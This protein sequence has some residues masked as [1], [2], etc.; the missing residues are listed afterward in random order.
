MFQPARPLKRLGLSITHVGP[1]NPTQLRAEA[2]QR[3][4]KGIPK[5]YQRDTKGIPKGYQ[6]DTKGIPKGYQK[7]TKGIPKVYKMDTKGIP[8]GYIAALFVSAW[9]CSHNGAPSR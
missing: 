6:M 4:T 5:G 7:Y 1:Y 8:Q 2:R 9:P 3:D